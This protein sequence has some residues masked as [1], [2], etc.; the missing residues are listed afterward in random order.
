M[1]LSSAENR[2]GDHLFVVQPIWRA[3]RY[4]PSFKAARTILN[5]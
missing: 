5:A 3:A 1:G 4:N 2:G